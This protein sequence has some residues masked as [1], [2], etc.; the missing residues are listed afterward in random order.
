MH[1]L[2]GIFL[3]FFALLGFTV[4]SAQDDVY[5]EPSSNYFKH[6]NT[7]QHKE[8]LHQEDYG[9][10]YYDDEGYSYGYDDGYRYHDDY[11]YSYPGSS[12]H[13]SFGWSPWVTFGW[14]GW[15]TW[16][17]YYPYN[18]W[19]AAPYYY[20]YGGG[21][22]GYYNNWNAY[23]YN[24]YWGGCNN[25]Y[26]YYGSCYNN[27]YGYPYYGGYA[28]GCGY[29]DWGHH[30]DWG[31]DG[32]YPGT[33]YG[34]RVSGNTGSSPRGP[35]TPPGITQPVLAGKDITAQ[36]DSPAIADIRTGLPGVRNPVTPPSGV[37]QS[38]TSIPQSRNGDVA[39]VGKDIPVDKE[40][41]RDITPG[42]TKRPVFKPAPQ[43]RFEPY[44]TTR[45]EETAST[46]PKPQID[47]P[48]YRPYTPSTPRN[49]TPASN[50]QP[51]PNTQSDRA[52]FKPERVEPK[53]DYTPSNPGRES[54]PDYTPSNPVRDAKPDYKPNDPGRDNRPS[55]TPPSR[56]DERPG[57]TPQ[58]RNHDADRNDRPSYSPPQR[59][60]PDSNDRPSDRS[61]SD[62]RPSYSPR[63]DAPSH[64]A[65]SRESSPS[66][67]GRSSGGSSSGGHS[68][69]GGG[70][71]HSSGSSSSHSSGG[72]SGSSASPRGRG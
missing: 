35:I 47:R 15:N 51:N 12:I 25:Y 13:I 16:N 56:I 68:P 8:S 2:K 24:N 60:Q 45:N 19:Y 28:G 65:P 67:G 71:S 59:P 72:S 40:L 38:P 49:S 70:S 42:V 50:D 21:C 6:Y 46:D 30:D 53:Q 63:N 52:D 23:T 54:K 41:P 18:N 14:W 10:T 69:S 26:S 3:P 5:Y 27:Y 33:Y 48:V 55:Y 44:P 32:Y 58:G 34:P 36:H 57:Y 29:D 43:E 7:I 39:H 66:S 17:Y 61:Q 31:H 9:V 64:S 4:L 22:G 1:A 37:D 62:D 20:G 11:G